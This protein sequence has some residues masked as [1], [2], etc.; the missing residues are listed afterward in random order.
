VRLILG[1]TVVALAAGI[2]VDLSL[3]LAGGGSPSAVW[4]GVKPR[5]AETLTAVALML[6]AGAL[7]A[8]MAPVEALRLE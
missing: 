1:E 5:D 7:A 8:G 4:C 2:A 3:A 6:G